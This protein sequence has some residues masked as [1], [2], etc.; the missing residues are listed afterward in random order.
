MSNIFPQNTTSASA[1]Q[2]QSS[3]SDQIHYLEKRINKFSF[4]ESLSLGKRKEIIDLCLNILETSKNSTIPFKDAKKIKALTKIGLDKARG[5][6]FSNFFISIFYKDYAVFT[7]L[8]KNLNKLLNI[9]APFSILSHI[10]IQAFNKQSA[11]LSPAY[12]ILFTSRIYEKMLYYNHNLNEKDGEPLFRYT[13]KEPFYSFSSEDF[14]SAED[15]SLTRESKFKERFT[16]KELSI[17]FKVDNNQGRFIRKKM[18]EISENELDD[19]LRK[20]PN[21]EIVYPTKELTAEELFEEGVI[22]QQNDIYYISNNFTYL[23][24]GFVSQ[25]ST[26]WTEL[27]PTNHINP[28]PD[29]HQLEIVVYSKHELPGI[30]S[31]QG[32]ASIKLTT[33]SG[34]VYDVGFY[35]KKEQDIQF[36]EGLFISPDPFTFAPKEVQHRHILKYSLTADAFKKIIQKIEEIKNETS[37][38]LEYHP[39]LKNCAAFARDIRDTALKLDASNITLNAKKFSWIKKA[40]LYPLL[41]I[42]EFIALNFLTNDFS[43]PEKKDL[44]KHEFKFLKSDGIYLPINLLFDKVIKENLQ[45]I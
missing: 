24:E 18:S 37:Q 36:E 19:I 23:D 10:K 22:K 34:E 8:L 4:Y 43:E 31:K 27:K 45:P 29:T 35:P 1:N 2:F 17:E 9:D 26:N 15:S 20:D 41:K 25:S 14:F 38:D 7:L 39:I 30:F 42:T 12:S 3:I 6:R 28:P 13:K 33:P 40:S 16:N 11:S 21:C 5:G 32:H 44:T